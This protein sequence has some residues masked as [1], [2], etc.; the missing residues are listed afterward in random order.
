MDNVYYLHN[1][2]ERVVSIKDTDIVHLYQNLLLKARSPFAR[3]CL[4]VVMM[5]IK[6]SLQQNFI[7]RV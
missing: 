3:Q 7:Q 1:K 4:R 2:I 5:Q 6:G